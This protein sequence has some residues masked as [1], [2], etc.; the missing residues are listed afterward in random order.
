MVTLFAYI[1]FPVCL[2]LFAVIKFV[3]EPEDDQ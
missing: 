1:I 3:L 2:I